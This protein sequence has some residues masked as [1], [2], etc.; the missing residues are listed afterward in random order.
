VAGEIPA[1]VIGREIVQA[2]A[3]EPS[4]WT[5]SFYE[6][7]N[8]AGVGEVAACAAGAEELSSCAAVGLYEGGFGACLCGGDGGHQPGWACSN[9]A[10]LGFHTPI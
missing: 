9:Y 7:V 6:F 10:H 5:I 4:E 1:E 8:G 3:Q 2:V